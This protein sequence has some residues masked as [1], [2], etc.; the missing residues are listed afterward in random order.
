MPD[1]FSFGGGVCIQGAK[2]AKLFIDASK[3]KNSN[4]LISHAHSD[5]AKTNCSSDFFASKET[6]EL[7]KKKA[8]AEARIHGHSFKKKFSLDGFDVSLHSSGHILGSSQSKIEADGKTVV[9]TSDFKLQKSLLFEPAEILAGDVLLIESTFGMPQFVFPERERVYGEMEK[10]LESNL[11]Q[12]R[13]VVM[14]GYATGKAQELTRIVNEFSHETPIV[15]ESIF[16]NNKIY[17]ANGVKLGKYLKLNHN[18]KE[19]SVL[20]M[21]PSLVDANLLEALSY[22]LGKK[23]V[24]ALATGW[25]YGNGYSKIF[26]LS[27]HADFSQ[28]T[29]YV[30][31][32]EPKLVLTHHGYAKEF[33]SSVQRK[34]KIPARALNA[35]GQKVLGEFA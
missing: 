24:S 8:S 12:N 17:E 29:R 3:S 4:V 30:K 22:S 18:L 31:E 5:H 19:S 1:L 35:K 9:A 16:E 32:A 20:I 34:L 7:V 11:K 2:G 23:V 27:D 10:W 26:P 14:A 21:P 6:A 13:F 15:H 25:H 33:A 28:L